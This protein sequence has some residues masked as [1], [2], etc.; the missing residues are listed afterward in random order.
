MKTVLPISQSCLRNQ[1]PILQVLQRYFTQPASVLELACGTA[2]HAVYMAKHLPHLN[3]HATDTKGQLEG[4]NLW[5]RHANLP[6]LGKPVELDVDNWSWSSSEDHPIQYGYCANLLHFV[7]PETAKS[8]FKGM[9]N[10][11]STGGLFAIYG[12]INEQG[13]TSEGNKNL[14]EW[15]KEDI[16]PLAGIKEFDDICTW[17]QEQGFTLTAKEAMPANN[18][19][20]FFRKD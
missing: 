15:L 19:L 14:D 4:A 20:L 5:V 3:W 18:Y 17:G 6:N 10:V 11:L 13:F 1:Q 9:K 16:N 2:Q 8:V 7:S 12:P